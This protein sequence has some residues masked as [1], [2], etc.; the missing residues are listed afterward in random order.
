MFTRNV[1]REY[2]L[3]CAG[4]MRDRVR[5]NSTTVTLVIF[6]TMTIIIHNDYQMIINPIPVPVPVPV[7]ISVSVNAV[8]PVDLVPFDCDHLNHHRNPQ[9]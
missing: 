5:E 9:R 7:P 8:H 2:R 1:D 4:R 6:N 3:Y